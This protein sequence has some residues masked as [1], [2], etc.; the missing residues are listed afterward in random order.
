M[1]DLTSSK[2]EHFTAEQGSALAQIVYCDSRIPP[3]ADGVTKI[4]VTLCHSIALL[5]TYTCPQS[6]VCVYTCYIIDSFIMAIRS[7]RFRSQYAV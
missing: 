6:T 2:K 7:F 1:A 4:T 3:T 5:S